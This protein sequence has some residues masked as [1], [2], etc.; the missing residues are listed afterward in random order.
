MS[1]NECIWCVLLDADGVEAH[2]LLGSQG[3]FHHGLEDGGR[4]ALPVNGHLLV[5]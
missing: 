5:A 2:V 4:V 3:V 1:Q